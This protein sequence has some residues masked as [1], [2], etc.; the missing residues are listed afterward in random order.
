MAGASDG[1]AGWQL[2][3]VVLGDAMMKGAGSRCFGFDRGRGGGCA[4][5]KL[6]NEKGMEVLSRREIRFALQRCDFLHP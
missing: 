6:A 4:W 3:R 1:V 2:R 5:D